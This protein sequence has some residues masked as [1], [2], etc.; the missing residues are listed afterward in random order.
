MNIKLILRG[1]AVLLSLAAI[2]F[3]VRWSGLGDLLDQGWIDR[4][5]RGKGLD[6]ELLF[7]AIGTLAT[8]VGFPRQVISFMGGYAF[9]FAWGTVLG[10]L[11]TV[12]GCIATFVYARLFGRALLANRLGGRIARVDAFVR[13]NPFTMT[14]LIRLLPVGSNV[15]TSLAAGL[16]SVAALPFLLGSAVGFVPQ[17]L[18]F[19]LVGSGV[20]VD[21]FWRIGLG[22]VLFVVSGVLGVYL[23][24]R[25]CHGKI[26]DEE[27]ERR[28]AG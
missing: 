3:L 9:G 23:Y 20:S 13:D 17:T 7:I 16:S 28:M 4:E 12:L 19:A 11:A 21:P 1:L 10:V 27:L 5:V 22:T 15:A 6:G 14:L 8:A 25:L 26:Y 18:V 2:G 24:R